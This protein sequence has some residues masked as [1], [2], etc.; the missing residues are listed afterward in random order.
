MTE[1]DTVLVWN[2]KRL[3]PCFLWSHDQWGQHGWIFDVRTEQYVD[4]VIDNKSGQGR[5][6]LWWSAG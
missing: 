5:L 3:Y 6:C 4:H 1:L 2:G